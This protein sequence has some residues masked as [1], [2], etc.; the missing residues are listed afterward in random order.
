MVAVKNAVSETKPKTAAGNRCCPRLRLP[1][2]GETP[3]PQ[4]G[5]WYSAD[6]S[7]PAFGTQRLVNNLYQVPMAVGM[8]SI[9]GPYYARNHN[10]SPSLGSVSRQE[11][12]SRL[13]AGVAHREISQ[14][15]AGY[16]NGANTYQLVMSNPVGKVDPAGRA[17]VSDDVNDE[18]ASGSWWEALWSGL[19]GA[20]LYQGPPIVTAP[21]GYEWYYM[22]TIGGYDPNNWIISPVDM[23]NPDTP[24][25]NVSLPGGGTEPPWMQATDTARAEL[26]GRG[27]PCPA[28]D[29]P[30]F[31]KNARDTLAF[32]DQTGQHPPGYEGGRDL[33]NP[34]GRLP[35]RGANGSPITYGEW[36]LNPFAPAN[37]SGIERLV[38]GSDGSAYFTDDHYTSFTRMR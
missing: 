25:I 12:K 9:T 8:D 6:W 27:G 17:G 14:G 22:P 21:Q 23:N 37:A 36:D 11:P 3:A 35:A 15:P 4:T 24:A 1:R 33:R 30:A 20:E 7:T 34:E 29:N 26:A 16:I 18:G 2:A 5:F 13:S 31:P 28:Y 19:F 32:V 38:T 10:N